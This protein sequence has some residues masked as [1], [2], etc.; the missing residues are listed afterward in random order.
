[1]ATLNTIAAV[2]LVGT[3]VATPILVIK[4]APRPGPGVGVAVPGPVV[5]ASVPAVALI[6]GYIWMVRRKK[7]RKARESTE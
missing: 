2:A 1:V 7:Q 4:P 6:G 3:V 5:G